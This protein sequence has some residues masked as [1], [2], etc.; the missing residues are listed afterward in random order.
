MLILTVLEKA[1]LSNLEGDSS[2][3]SVTFQTE[4]QDPP[5]RGDTTGGKDQPR[6]GTASSPPQ[7]TGQNMDL[8]SSL[9]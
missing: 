5:W 4:K 8:C 9:P 7:R 6:L 2:W 1:P 3:S